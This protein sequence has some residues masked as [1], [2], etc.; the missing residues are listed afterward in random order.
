[1]ASPL[2]AQHACAA[3]AFFAAARRR[4]RGP[5]SAAAAT[6]RNVRGR[7][8]AVAA[9]GADV[10]KGAKRTARVGVPRRALLRGWTAAAGACC[11][12]SA[13]LP[14]AGEAGAVEVTPPMCTLLL[15][16]LALSL[17]QRRTK[18]EKAQ[19]W[20]HIS[21]EASKIAVASFEDAIALLDVLRMTCERASDA[22]CAQRHARSIESIQQNELQ[23]AQAALEAASTT[24]WFQDEL[25]NAKIEVE[26]FERSYELLREYTLQQPDGAAWL[27][28]ADLPQTELSDEV[29]RE[30]ARTWRWPEAQ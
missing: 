22:A 19:E 21:V 13:F 12:V 29:L 16:K 15:R 25:R 27:A 9:R 1:M 8:V 11:L 7:I 4:E 17:Q 3:R 14:F 20:V 10:S 6:P 23:E 18:L 26:R 2:C 5:C 24:G 28:K 30:Q